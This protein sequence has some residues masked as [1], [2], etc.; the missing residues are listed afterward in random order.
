VKEAIPKGCCGVILDTGYSGKGEIRQLKPLV[1]SWGHKSVVES[2]NALAEGTNLIPSTNPGQL[3][4]FCN[5]TCFWSL[6]MP[7]HA[8]ALPNPNTRGNWV[9]RV[10]RKKGLQS[11]GNF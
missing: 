9:T 7:V 4:T 2:A 1:E 3:T 11:T 10:Q 8:F 6:W 5:G